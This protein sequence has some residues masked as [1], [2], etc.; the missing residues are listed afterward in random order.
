MKGRPLPHGDT[1][2]DRKARR[3]G[4][5]PARVQAPVSSSAK[6]GLLYYPV[7]ITVYVCV[8]LLPGQ[9]VLGVGDNV[10]PALG[11]LLGLISGLRPDSNQGR[12]FGGRGR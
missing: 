1:G 4:V 12:L 5:G 6:Q 9:P 10:M 7:G 3:A 2:L 8:F 11:A